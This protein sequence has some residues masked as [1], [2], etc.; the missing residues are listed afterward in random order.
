MND[1]CFFRATNLGLCFNTYDDARKSGINSCSK[2]SERSNGIGTP[3]CSCLAVF[4]GDGFTGVSVHET[5]N[6]ALELLFDQRVV[7]PAALRIWQAHPLAQILRLIGGRVLVT[8]S[9]L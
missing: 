1:G 7:F 2:Y 5:V 6:T 8:M 9:Y 4:R 3:P